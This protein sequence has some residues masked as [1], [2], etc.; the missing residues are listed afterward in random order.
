MGTG[1]I[2]APSVG[3][4]HK[5]GEHRV[6]GG[7]RTE[8]A[9]QP[10]VCLLGGDDLRQVS[11]IGLRMVDLI[12]RS[13]PDAVTGADVLVVTKKLDDRAGVAGVAAPAAAL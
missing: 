4:E 3:A 5:S 9:K 1:F 12:G 11:E 6:E 10:P 8:P 2:K 7:S 13:N